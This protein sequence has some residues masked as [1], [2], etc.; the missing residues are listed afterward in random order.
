L[1]GVKEADT[2]GLVLLE[3]F[4][5]AAPGRVQYQPSGDT[6]LWRALRGLLVTREDVFLDYGSGKGKVVLQAALRYPFSKVIGVDISEELT[7]I[8]RSNVEGLRSRFR[9]AEVELVVA[10]A[11]EWP[12]P[13]EVT[14]V[15]MYRPFKEAL[16]ETVLERVNESLR[17]K[18]RKLTLA[19]AY[20]EQEDVVL[21]HGFTRIRKSRGPNK[22]PQY[23]VGVYVRG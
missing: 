9:A 6:W 22:I 14:Y 23:T 7:S 10:D 15:Y 11:A 13:D 8:G 17:R 3:E 20:P 1:F 4:G 18:P 12:L 16:F 21:R 19:Y 2:E 5:L